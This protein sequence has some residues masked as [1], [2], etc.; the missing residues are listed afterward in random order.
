MRM[1]SYN[2][3]SSN[4]A[5]YSDSAKYLGWLA[6]KFVDAGCAYFC[7]WGPGC[8]LMHDAVDDASPLP[9]DADSVLMTTWHADDSIEDAVLF[10]LERATPAGLYE[11][12]CNAVILAVEDRNGWRRDAEA[13]AQMSLVRDAI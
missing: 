3:A 1:T 5:D 7:A 2:C 4:Y 8:E 6:K 11:A 12:N 9:D 10:A 13:A